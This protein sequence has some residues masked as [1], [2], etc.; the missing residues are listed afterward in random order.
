MNE[1]RSERGIALLL[2]LMAMLCMT[3]FGLV[4]MLTASSETIVAGRYRHGEAARYAAEAAAER[5]LADLSTTAGDW[6]ALIDGSTRST[7]V[8]GPPG[9]TRT[10]PDG[11]SIDLDQ[12]LNM[13]NCQRTARCSIGEMNAVT[14]D[15]PW[16][17]NNPRWQLLAYA[18][19][20]ALVTGR[21]LDSAYYAVVLVGDDP[22]ETDGDPMR[23][24]SGSAN[25]GSGII[26]VRA[27]AFGAGGVVRAIDLTVARPAGTG[28]AG[29]YNTDR[30]RQTGV[31]VLSWREVR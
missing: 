16:G 29:G 31:R 25:P 2:A 19:L 14:A 7:F 3:A 28:Q 9:G 10:L 17:A 6:N 21:S 4:L 23:D 20:N 11:S 13:A 12:E 22:A 24:G 15:R 8:D 18:P 30:A 26:A 5:A 1:R 27:L